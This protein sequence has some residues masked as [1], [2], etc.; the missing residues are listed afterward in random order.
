MAESLNRKRC[1]SFL[2]A[3][4]A[5]VAA[6][7]ALTAR[8]DDGKISDSKGI[9]LTIYNQNFGLVRDSRQMELKNGIN[10]VSCQDVAAKI[11]PTSVSFT[12]LTAPNQ[13]V[14]REQNYKYDLIDPNTILNK[15]I[16]KPAKFKQFVG[17]GSVVDPYV[18]PIATQPAS[19]ALRTSDEVAVARKEHSRLDLVF[20]SLQPAEKAFQSDEL[21][22]AL[23][24]LAVAV[25]HRA[26]AWRGP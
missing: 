17:N 11:D 8:A 23:E 5:T 26:D 21:A 1:L 19:M 16:G 22:V 15:S 13:V 14:V 10:Y 20:L 2:L 18:Q 7:N 6:P 12:S 4:T 24:Q 9:S 3:I 25:P